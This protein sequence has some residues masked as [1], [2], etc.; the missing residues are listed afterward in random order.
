[1]KSEIEKKYKKDFLVLL[2]AEDDESELFIK[3]KKS[4]IFYTAH[5]H[6]DEDSVLIKPDKTKIYHKGYG[7]N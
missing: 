7:S 5:I 1:M 2:T 4:L 3:L 6:C